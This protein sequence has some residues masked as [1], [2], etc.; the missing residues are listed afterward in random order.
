MQIK[1]ELRKELKSKRKNIEKKAQ[2]DEFIREN[3]ICSD[4]YLDAKQVLFYASL[5][6]EINID[7]CI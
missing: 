5:D 6:D 7:E 3:L 1:R 2:N 4:L